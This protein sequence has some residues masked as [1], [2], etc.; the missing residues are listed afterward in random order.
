MGGRT[1]SDCAGKGQVVK[2]VQVWDNRKKQFTVLQRA[3][4]CPSC[5][6]RGKV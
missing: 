5:G 6:G 3:V 4:M 2:P 1:C